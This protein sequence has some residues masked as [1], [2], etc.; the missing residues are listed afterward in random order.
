MLSRQI[1]FD[2]FVNYNT[3]FLNKQT[4]NR[5]YKERVSFCH[6]M[7]KKVYS[8]EKYIPLCNQSKTLL[9]FYHIDWAFDSFQLCNIEYLTKTRI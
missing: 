8:H 7:K 3:S 5:S 2:D 4:I 1:V 9:L 6:K